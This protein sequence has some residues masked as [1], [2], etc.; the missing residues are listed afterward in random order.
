MRETSNT[1]SEMEAEN[2]VRRAP[3]RIEP[4]YHS[5]SVSRGPYRD[6]DVCRLFTALVV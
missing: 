2:D 5:A 1:G 3:V 6:D 4:K